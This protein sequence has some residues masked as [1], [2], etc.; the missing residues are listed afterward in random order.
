MTA[1][2]GRRAVAP[3]VRPVFSVW[4]WLALTPF[5]LAAIAGNDGATT[6]REVGLGVLAAVLVHAGLLIA[7]LLLAVMERA[8][9]DRPWL[10]WSIV[11]GGL[12]GIAVARP[13]LISTLQ[14]SLGVDLVST[15][16]ALRVFIN[17]VVLTL[18]CLLTYALID[19]AVRS[20][21]AERRLRSVLEALGAEE[22]RIAATGAWVGAAFQRELANRVLDA[23][24]ELLHRQPP[25]DVLASELRWIARSVV[26]RAGD[27]AR[28]AAL[29]EA[30]ADTG[31]LPVMPSSDQRSTAPAS[32]RPG[33]TLRAG[34]G[35]LI[36]LIV[37]VLLLPAAIASHG[38]LVG[39]LL[40]IVAMAASLLLTSAIERVPLPKRR[41]SALAVR[42]L[43]Y[44]VTSTLSV[45]ILLGTV[46]IIP[47]V[48][49]YL[50]YGAF[51]YTVIALA[52]SV[53]TSGT[54]ALRAA[55]RD[56]A[57]AIAACE[58]RRFETQRSLAT[59]AARTG[60]LF[61]TDVQ[62]DVLA[63]SFR[64][65]AGTAPPEALEELIDRVESVLR[66]GAEPTVAIPAGIREG[67]RTTLEAWSRALDV[68][69]EL[70]DAALEWL[71]RHP[72]G[73][74]LAHQAITEGLTNVVRH[75]R[76]ARAIVGLR[77]VG[78]AVEVTVRSPGR[79]R[80]READGFGLRS[81]ESRADAVELRQLG[82]DVELQVRI[83]PRG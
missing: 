61:D 27:A 41:A 36:T 45:W 49:Y 58:Q 74:G 12:L 81:L 53:I 34:P 65:D 35:W 16:P 73:A 43:L 31:S 54:R 39:P 23:L 82:A 29:D 44:G 9:G 47:L 25:P 78:D 3:S 67:L 46:E 19:T 64:I 18:G 66:Q 2:A 75:S 71:S 33:S 15:A 60:A 20:R 69:T 76:S 83:G 4:A 80:A 57:T 22:A 77:S 10:R 72:G 5:L 37:T 8:T 11:G 79:L 51:A 70:D 30:I 21:E 24:G 13:A 52:L 50:V 17:L 55:E 7:F 1:S 38:P 14:E 62:G 26:Q 40:L 32:P 6:P 42:A 68:E 59:E 63:T 56:A 28:E 48:A